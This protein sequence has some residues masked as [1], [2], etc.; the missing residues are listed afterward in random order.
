[1]ER[2]G[3]SELADIFWYIKEN[4]SKPEGVHNFIFFTRD[5]ILKTTREEKITP[6]KKQ[7]NS[8]RKEKM[9]EKKS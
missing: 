3:K 4:C 6:E 2:M 1:M 8:T 7:Q 5:K 9:P